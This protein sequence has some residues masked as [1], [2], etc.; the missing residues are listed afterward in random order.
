MD[1]NQSNKKER[2]TEAIKEL[3]KAIRD[4]MPPEPIVPLQKKLLNFII[5]LIFISPRSWRNLYNALLETP[6]IC[7]DFLI[8]L[9]EN[10]KERRI[11]NLTFQFFA[12]L[13]FPFGAILFIGSVLV[14]WLGYLFLLK[15]V[16]IDLILRSIIL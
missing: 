8:A 13:F 5:V 14:F 3:D 11:I 6:S 2:G 9:E 4:S 15:M 7:I 12:L 16:L 1:A 10:L